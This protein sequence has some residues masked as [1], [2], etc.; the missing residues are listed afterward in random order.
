MVS[1]FYYLGIKLHCLLLGSE[2]VDVSDC[3]FQ[4]ANKA[5]S[6]LLKDELSWRRKHDLPAPQSSSSFSATKDLPSMSI[7]AFFQQK[8]D[9][10]AGI[11]RV[12]SPTKSDEPIPLID[13]TTASNVDKVPAVEN[14]K[15]IFQGNSFSISAIQ[16]LI[17]EKSTSNLLDYLCSM[18]NQQNADKPPRE[19]SEIFSL[20]VSQNA[21]YT[22]SYSDNE[23]VMCKCDF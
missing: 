15:Q 22:T 18:Q 20:P 7:G 13:I 3:S 11:L 23:A 10:L 16:Q 12:P 14:E 6:R 4:S 2:M 1:L 5:E 17:S 21:S 19:S 9:N 8:S